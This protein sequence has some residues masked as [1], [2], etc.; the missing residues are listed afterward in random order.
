MGLNLVGN[1]NIVR[2]DIT[3]KI[4][5]QAVYGYDINPQHIGLNPNNSQSTNMLFMGLIRCPYP[6]ANL[7]SI[8]TSK[9]DAAGYVTL[10]AEDLPTWQ[11]WSTA[12]RQYTPLPL[13]GRDQ[14][15]YS[16]QPVAAVAAP[17]SDLVENAAALVD[18][19]Y[20]VLP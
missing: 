2:R 7:L 18:V 5:G 9:A 15:L 8:D 10:T 13:A 11:Y 3:R 6:R 4:T 17:T 14:I 19:Q 20:E 1:P 16:G 12:G